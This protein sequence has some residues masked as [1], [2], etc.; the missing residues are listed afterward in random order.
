MAKRIVVA[1]AAVTILQCLFVLCLVSALQ[2]QVPRN[3]PFGATGASPVLNAASSKTSLQTTLYSNESSARTAINQSKAYGV[4]VQ[5]AGGG[6][7]LAS[8]QKSFFAYTEYVPLFD[9][10]GKKLGQPVKLDDVKP[11]P[12][13]D[14]IGAV[15]G[16]LM[17]PTLIGGLLAA[18]LVFKATG[19]AAQRW[20]AVTLGAYAV[21]GALVT[22]L[23][24]G[25]LIG[26]YS[27]SH[28][29]PLLGCFAL[30]TAAV[31]FFAAG[32]QAILKSI[33]TVL[34]IISMII[35]G[36]SGGGGTGSAIL[37][38]YWQSIGAWLPPR[39][40]IELYRNTIY[41]GGHEITT[42]LAVL[43][44]YGFI[45][46]CLIFPGAWLRDRV[47]TPVAAAPAG[48]SAVAAEAA[49]ASSAAPAG[50]S[51]ATSAATSSATNPSGRSNVVLIVAALGIVLFM[52]FL[53]SLNY[54]SSAHEP[55]AKNLPFGVTGASSL[56]TAVQDSGYSLKV[57]QYPNEQAAKNAINS[58]KLFGAL[59]PGAT[60]STLLVVPTA[61]D[62]APADLTVQFERAATSQHQ[63]LQVKEYAPKPLVPKDPFGIVQGLMIAPLLIGGYLSANLLRTAT[64]AASARWRGVVLAGYSLV[65]G[66]LIDLIV[67]LGLGGYPTDK[68]WIVWP[69]L[70]LI[71]YAVSQVAAVL[72][73]LLGA[74]GTLLTIIV[75]ILLGNP[76]S[77]GANGVPYLP[78]FWRSIGPYLPPRNAYTLLHNTIY[79]SG[80]GTTQALGVL[81]AYAGVFAII[82]GVLDWYRTPTPSIPVTPETENE[83]AAMA[84]PVTAGP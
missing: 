52:Q 73:K 37:P 50:A 29:W 17:L 72:G 5:G 27:N 35:V 36:A 14:R 28:F 33:G 71:I 51:T 13:G 10:V 40:A 69:I 34:V 78:G 32:I 82:L 68:F 48:A 75:I 18:V 2:I 31:A 55:V 54:M 47:S 24:A 58:A 1:L 26:A 76:S 8:E 57:S 81:L 45:G 20:R 56:T 46:L 42:P 84:I 43:G 23:V 4:Y 67:C 64:G 30:V 15:V 12:R 38:T 25:P 61:S 83:A 74:A 66:L 11:L 6:T 63:V 39:Y 41:F 9:A 60:S 79:F 21:I 62:L 65:A 3:M 19:R 77:G 70:A 44:V 80:H 16:L 7:L 59:I 49:A 22:D 53:F